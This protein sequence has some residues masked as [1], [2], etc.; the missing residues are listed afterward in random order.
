M[1]EDDWLNRSLKRGSES[2]RKIP[3]G[4]NTSGINLVGFLNGCCE[5]SPLSWLLRLS[6]LISNVNCRS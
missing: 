3:H 1:I 5:N 6:M 2:R 4:D